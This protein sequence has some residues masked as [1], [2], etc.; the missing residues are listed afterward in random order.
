MQVFG[1]GKIG[2]TIIQERRAMKN[3]VITLLPQQQQHFLCDLLVSVGMEESVEF[4][5]RN[6]R[7]FF[8]N[9]NCFEFFRRFFLSED[10]LLVVLFDLNPC[11]KI[12]NDI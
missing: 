1:P 9:D 3:A 4:D 2:N 12:N 11:Y 8:A 6:F 5:C 7:S 10:S